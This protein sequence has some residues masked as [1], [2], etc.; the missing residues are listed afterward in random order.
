MDIS[1][2]I[3]SQVVVDWNGD[4]FLS[5]VGMFEVGVLFFGSSFGFWDEGFG[6]E[7]Y[8]F[9]HLS[10]TFIKGELPPFLLL[11]L[12]DG[13]FDPNTWPLPVRLMNASGWLRPPPPPMTDCRDLD[14]GLVFRF[15]A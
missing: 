3:S 6:G 9:A 11:L 14:F 1:S 5:S 10:R 2:S 8:L 12:L 4:T 13:L 15:V 7:L